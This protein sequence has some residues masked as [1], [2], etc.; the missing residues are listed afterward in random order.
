MSR[1]TRWVLAHRRRVGAFWAIVTVAGV[2]AAGPATHSFTSQFA[3]PGREG[4]ETNL[5]IARL[6]HQGGAGAPVLA[7]VT[8]PAGRTVAS[9]GVRAQLQS[10]TARA[11]A[12]LPGSRVASWATT[13]SRAFV[14]ADGRTTFLLAYPVPDHEAFGTDTRAARALTS[15]LAG[16]RV[17]GARVLVTG[18]DALQSQT[19]GSGGPSVLVES[20]L[21]GLGALAVLAFVFASLLAFV[22]LVMAVVSIMSTFLILW[23]LAQIT[24][25]SFI[26]EFLVALIGLGVAIDY[27]LL[28][29]VR[30]REERARGL[31]GD[32]AVVRAMQT[33]GRAV[34]FSGTTVAIGLLAL[35]VLPLP[36]LR[37]IGFA[38]M[39]IPLV[40][41]IVATTLLPIVLASAGERLDWPHLRSERRASA[42]WT[43]W[44][45][46][47]VSRRWPAAVIALALLV[48]LGLAATSLQPGQANLNTL[49]RGGEAR[50]G[51]AALERAGIGPGALTPIEVLAPAGEAAAVARAVAAVPGVHGAVAPDTA[52]WRRDGTAIVDA[53]A[54][55]DGSTAAGQATID[56]VRAAAHRA[57]R[58]V[59]VGGT[60]AENE[61]FVSAIYGSFPLMVAL[62]ALLT[63]LLLAR[64][65]R[66]LLL[67]LKAVALNVLSVGAAWGVITLVWQDGHG[68]AALWGIPATHSV[69]AWIPLMVFA[70]LFGLS[71]DYE[72]FILARMREEYD[73]GGSTDAAVV[74]GIGRTGRLVTSAALILF[75][76]FVSMA[77]AP[78]TDVKVFAT[79]LAAGIMLDA[80]VIR[81]LLVPAVV[82][83]LG[84]WNWWLPARPARL[85]RVAPSPAAVQGA[86]ASP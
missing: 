58:D 20:V 46:L 19:G 59:R 32:E 69:S 38:G 53:F 77:T 23:G 61:D 22:P 21:G 3:A 17:G 82:S 42:A 65:F 6:Y 36:F 80:T 24:S 76:A 84:R 4:F 25:V 44:A 50:A 26:V 52:A 81:A 47:V 75:L 64:A 30:W 27:S 5:Q 2:A 18:V 10:L 35:V 83:L 31:T 7:E 63:Y 12:A 86:G 15:A 40:S 72:V 41:V 14:S 79:G 67:P 55:S 66:S 39:L 48:A 33:A 29:V 85:L 54:V 70:F 16:A 34:A 9:P 43:R 78:N 28:V 71:M 68:S 74:R 57:G 60:G 51:L 62:I 49:S 73:A 11:Q 8:L 56:R 45:G 1:I 37:S 13:G